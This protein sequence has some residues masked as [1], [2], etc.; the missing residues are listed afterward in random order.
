MHSSQ[1]QSNH[2][3]RISLCCHI[4]MISH[5]RCFEPMRGGVVLLNKRTFVKSPKVA[6]IMIPLPIVYLRCFHLYNLVVMFQ[7]KC[8][9]LTNQRQHLTIVT[10]I[11]IHEMNNNLHNLNGMV[12][13][14]IL[15]LGI[16]AFEF[17]LC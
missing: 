17:I 1:P 4:R 5:K 15:N 13:F 2:R 7:S 14:E 11:A 3:L 10:L 8:S 12:P 16:Y 9:R 6:L